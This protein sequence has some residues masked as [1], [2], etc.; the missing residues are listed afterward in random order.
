[1]SFVPIIEDAQRVACKASIM[2]EGLTGTGKSGLALALGYILAGEDWSK[3]GC[4]DTEN[5]SLK[6]FAQIPSILGGKIGKFKIGELTSD[7]GYDPKNYLTCGQI[8]CC[9]CGRMRR[10]Y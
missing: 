6:L 10:L 5:K 7:I 4:V 2:L 3:V 9:N 1:M 8:L